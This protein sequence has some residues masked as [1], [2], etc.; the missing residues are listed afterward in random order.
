MQVR[1][2]G[3]A[4][5][6]GVVALAASAEAR[7]GDARVEIMAYGGY[8]FGGSAEGS[9]SLVTRRA[10]ILSSPSYGAALD[11]KLHGGAFGELSWSRQDTTLVLRRSDGQSER[12]D[13][14][15]DYFQ[16]G[17]LLEFHLPGNEWLFPVFGGTVG[18]TWYDASGPE[19]DYDEWRLS[20]IFEGGLKVRIVQALG[21]R[22]RA[23]LLTTF[24]TD[25]SAL[26]C[27]SEVGCTLAYSGTAVFQGE[28]GAGVYLAF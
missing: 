14:A 16:L 23:R 10:S 5:A 21:V 25:E 8:Q 22:L 24:L 9:E 3:L 12:Y 18:A 27:G 15:V 1:S 28:V 2:R 26:F 4:A 7:A 11:L 19:Y 17:G 20:L 13:L 6:V